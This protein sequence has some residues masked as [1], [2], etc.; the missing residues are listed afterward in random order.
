MTFALALALALQDPSPTA[1]LVRDFLGPDDAASRAARRKLLERGPSALPFLLDAR[2]RRPAGPREEALGELVLDLK[3]AA[4]GERGREPLRKLRARRMTVDM[5]DAPVAAVLDYLREITELNLVVDP[6]MTSEAKAVTLKM[7]DRPVSEVL[8]RLLEPAKLDY[9]FRH[10]TIYLAP[11]DRLWAAPAD[12][13]PPAPLAG[14]PAREARALLALLSS[15]AAPERDRATR[16]LRALGPPVLP[17]LEEAA[18]GSDAETA[19]RCRD[20]AAEL[21]PR[22]RIWGAIPP[23][24][25]WRG[26]TLGGADLAVAAKIDRMKIDLAFEAAELRDILDFVRD[27][28]E[29]KIAVEEAYPK[30]PVTFKVKDLRLGEVLELLTL[31]YG[32]DVRIAE[33]QV[34]IFERKK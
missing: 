20:L 2:E 27:F 9:D 29:L 10:G 22:P 23:A 32:F 24:G 11:P 26:Q 30:R 21:R 14:E 19:A 6:A 17:L 34:T 4:A 7:T 33:G 31:P 5:Q 28:S 25:H 8:A 1:D 3:E 16:A 18:R 13:K 12:E 15:D